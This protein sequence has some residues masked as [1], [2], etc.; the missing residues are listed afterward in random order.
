MEGAEGAHDEE[1]EGDGFNGLWHSFPA[2][3]NPTKVE[4]IGTYYPR[5]PTSTLLLVPPKFFLAGTEWHDLEEITFVNVE[6]VNYLATDGGI[7]SQESEDGRRRGGGS[8]P[9]SLNIIFD[10]TDHWRSGRE[11]STMNSVAVALAGGELEGQGIS[12][13]TGSVWWFESSERM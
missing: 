10:V 7:A 5:S 12:I 13:G 2:L 11:T 3:L 9:R 8:E 6:T 1:N 4:I